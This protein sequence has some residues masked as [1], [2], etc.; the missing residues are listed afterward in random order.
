MATV[1]DPRRRMVRRQIAGRGVTDRRVLAAME[2]VPREAFLPEALQEFA[3]EDT[4]LPI[5]EGQTMSQ[6][7]IVARMV[8]ARRCRRRRSRA[9]DR[10]GL[11]LRRG[12]AGRAGRPTCSPSS[13]IPPWPISPRAGSRQLGYGDNVGVRTGDGTLGWPEQAPFD[14]IIAAAG[15][16]RVPEALARPAR[17]RGPAGDAGR[18]DADCISA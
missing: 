6:P 9:R 17:R 18:R 8:E 14:A 11:G 4:P 15:G 16:P 5:E 3:Y 7:Y 2:E 12:R 13:A 1:T 10:R